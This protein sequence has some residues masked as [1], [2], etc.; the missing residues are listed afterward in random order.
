MLNDDIRIR[1]FVLDSSK[2]REIK[3]SVDSGLVEENTTV[4]LTTLT[5]GA[6]IYYTTEGSTPDDSSTLYSAPITIDADMTLKAI[7]IKTGL[8]NSE[9]L[10]REFTVNSSLGVKTI[11]EIQGEG[12]VSP[13]ELKVVEDVEGIVTATLN[14]QFAQ[15]GDSI[16]GFYM[17]GVDDNNPS[18]SEAIFVKTNKAVEIGDHVTVTGTVIEQVKEQDFYAYDQDNQLA[19][20]T[21]QN[22]T[23]TIDSSGNTLPDAIVLGEGGR[24]VPHD[25]ISSDNFSTYDITTYAIDFYES[26]ECMRV[27]VNN[28]LIVGPSVNRVVT[29]VPDNGALA[30][31]DGDLNNHGGIVLSD[32]DT[33]TEKL[34]LNAAIKSDVLKTLD[35][36][37]M[38]D[39][40]SGPVFG[41]LEYEWTAYQIYLTEDAP[42][43]SNPKVINDVYKYDLDDAELRIAS[44]NVYNHGGD[45]DTSK[46]VGI[47]K[48]IV[49]NM[50]NPDIIGLVEVQDNDGTSDDGVVDASLTYQNFIDEVV[51]LG[52]PTYKWT[53]ISPI[54]N[55]EGGAPGGNIR[56]GFLYNPERV[57]LKAGIKGS[58]TESVTVD[59][60]GH[61]VNNPGRIATDASAFDGTRKSLAAEFTFNGED[62]IVIANHFKSKGGDNA[63]YGNIQPAIK[64]TEVKRVQ[65]AQLVN[66]FIDTVLAANPEANVIAL[67]D[68]N[69]YQFSN[70][71]KA[72]AGD[73]MTNLINT[74]PLEE[75]FSYMF[76]GNAQILDHI[77][78]TNNLKDD[79]KVDIINI[80]SVLGK[81]NR[82]SDHDPVI[83]AFSNIGQAD[84]V[85]P[86]TSNISGDVT[87]GTSLELTTTTDEAIIYYS[88]GVLSETVTD[89]MLYSTPLVV[90][91]AMTITAVAVKAE[92]KSTVETIT[93]NPIVPVVEVSQTGSIVTFTNEVTDAVIYYSTSELDLD[94][95]SNNQTYSDA[96]EIT[97]ATTFKVIAVKGD[98][99]SDVI[100]AAV[101][102]ITNNTVLEAKTADKGTEVILDVIVTSIGASGSKGFTFQD[103]TAGG[104]VYT[105]NLDELIVVGSHVL[106][107]GT[108]DLYKGQFQIRMTSVELLNAVDMPAPLDIDA[109]GVVE[110]NVSRFVTMTGIQVGEISTD[111]YGS[112]YIKGVKDNQ[113]VNIKLDNRCGT[114][115][116]EMKDIIE[117]DNIIT[118]TGFVSVYNDKYSLQGRSK[119]DF[120]VTGKMPKLVA[121]QTSNLENKTVTAFN[122]NEFVTVTVETESESD[123]KGL[124]LIKITQ[125]NKIVR[126]GFVVNTPTNNGHVGLGFDTYGLTPGTYTVTAYLWSDLASAEALARP[127]EVTFDIN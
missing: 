109:T 68:L 39:K 87:V 31:L 123:D 40:I 63:P 117:L 71:A 95:L 52:G 36:C 48:Q 69:D 27:T 15:S 66:D 98:L 79:A 84:F 70:P 25:N 16:T 60:E 121:L 115:F 1:V 73:V 10:V 28:P 67:G 5:E 90:N 59:A 34:P 49:E 51:K 107:K 111:N 46:T 96:I 72:I 58:S 32:S 19:V 23:I 88:L 4:T 57:T 110:E 119:D 43:I 18:T 81:Y 54:N 112:T 56:V 127:V 74:L 29:I 126:L 92:F 64:T 65:Q 105:K 93:V 11:S 26:L 125:E 14:Y 44:Y 50:L 77:I 120:V 20:T 78:V 38:G 55:D 83:A 17:Q 12:H 2:V 85:S 75:Q 47:A 124:V 116:D 122:Q 33:N 9:E 76:G 45:A 89:N 62:V 6:N 80:N 61:L 35:D 113:V 13:F 37:V 114:K 8:S 21:L 53:D 30:Q 22:V 100:T 86:V 101:A 108:T 103:D 3:S 99:K 94:T 97:S 42:A 106:L 82:H 102:P 104:Y 7:A 118:V 24:V 41:I 91:E